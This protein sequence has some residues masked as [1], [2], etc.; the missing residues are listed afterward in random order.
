ML[1]VVR[2]DSLAVWAAP[3]SG[4]SLLR[5]VARRYASGFP[6]AKQLRAALVCSTSTL[7]AASLVLDFVQSPQRALASTVAG[8]KAMAGAEGADVE[9]V[10]VW[11]ETA[12]VRPLPIE[13]ARAVT[14]EEPTPCA[15]LPGLSILAALG[16]QV[17]QEDVHAA[18]EAAVETISAWNDAAATGCMDHRQWDDREARGADN[19]M[20]TIPRHFHDVATQAM[21]LLSRWDEA[22]SSGSISSEVTQ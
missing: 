13:V 12:F 5:L 3:L 22:E 6:G 7:H 9:S 15:E 21:D 14:A 2:G 19:D 20:R 18:A 11:D 16:P 8:V 1:P 4:L 17:T 10:A